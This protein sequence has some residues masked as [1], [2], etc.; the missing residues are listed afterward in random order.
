[1][2]ILF[3]MHNQVDDSCL[4]GHNQRSDSSLLRFNQRD[5]SFLLRLNQHST[6]TR[7]QRRPRV[8][9]GAQ[10]FVISEKYAAQKM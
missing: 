3:L 9:I 6:G 4:L 2:M 8:F 1:M 5:D 7:L 10:M